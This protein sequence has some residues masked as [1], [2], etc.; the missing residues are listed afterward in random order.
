VP[1]LHSKFS[2]SNF[3]ANMLCPG[4][5]AMSEGIADPGS[6]YADE[7]TAAHT[8]FAWCLEQDRDAA[9]FMGRRIPVG[10]RTFEV[11]DDMATPVQTAVRNTREIVGDGMLLSEQRVCYAK[12]L[13]VPDDDAWGTSDVIAARG[14]ELQVHDYKHGRGVEVDAEDNAQMLL[15]AM[16]ALL[17]VDDVLGPFET[18]RMVI[19]QPRIKDAPSEW[20]IS[21][22]RVRAWAETTGRKAVEERLGAERMRAGKTLTQAQW[23]DIYLRPNEKSCKFCRAKATCPK[24]R[25]EAAK[26]VFEVTPATPDE[27]DGLDVAERPKQS[28]DAWLAAVMAKADLIEDYLKAVR[29]EVESRLLAGRA[30]EGWKIVQGRQGNR[31]WSD[32]NA[33]EQ[34]LKAMR[35]PTEVMYDLKLISPTTA[36][37]L[38]KAKTIG[39][40]QWKALQEHVTRS[41][42]AKHVAPVTDPRP[43][44]E[45]TPVEDDFATVSSDPVHDFA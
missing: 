33:V 9:A 43:A 28:D 38:A 31:A 36:E 12:P 23:E 13:G 7:G 26:T 16:G 27:F 41:D 24:L 39:P 42:G 18:V 34:Q 11:D 4:R 15:Y 8:L 37:K 30:I 21:A 32:A 29:A 10:L 40:R 17:A 22:A 45:L 25:N 6:V 3:E 1:E 19:H 44:L 35:L 20:V 2:A 14:T 5:A